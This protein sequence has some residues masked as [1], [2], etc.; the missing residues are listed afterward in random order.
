VKADRPEPGFGQDAW[1]AWVP[2]LL[3]L[4]VI[5]AESSDFFSSQ[6]TGNVLYSLLTAILGQIDPF[7]F[8]VWH[9]YLRKAGHAAGYGLLSLFFFRAWRATLLLRDAPRW[10][11]RWARISLLTTVVV[12]GVD[13]WHQ[14]YLPARSGNVGDV[15]LDSAAALAVQVLL[16]AW[17]RKARAA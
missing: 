12:A 3:W 2:A 10:A 5:S 11:L 4:G 14:S 6:R 16:W 9:G 8:S 15:M 17:L 7:V 1:K 13:E